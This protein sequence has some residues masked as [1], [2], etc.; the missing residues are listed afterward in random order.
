MTAE[1]VSL[2]TLAE[3]REAIIAEIVGGMPDDHRHFL[4]GFKKGA[5]DWSLLGLSHVADLPAVKWRLL[6]LEKATNRDA[7]I[8]KLQGV[9][10]GEG[11]GP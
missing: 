11:E 7:Q 2:D 1:P 8:A 6:N 9:L 5:P 4:L 3:A 10:F